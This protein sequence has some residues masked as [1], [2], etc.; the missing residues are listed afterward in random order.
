MAYKPNVITT[1]AL[2]AAA[3]EG[4]FACIYGL[5]IASSPTLHGVG[6]YLHWPSILL[7]ERIIGDGQGYRLRHE[8]LLNIAFQF[9]ALFL[10]ILAMRMFLILLR[11]LNSKA[12]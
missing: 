10:L 12:R 7:T 6:S 8:F 4:V 9:G 11:S 5:G 1:A 2:N 3:V